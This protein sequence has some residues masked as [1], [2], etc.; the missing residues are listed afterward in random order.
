MRESSTAPAARDAGHVLPTPKLL[1]AAMQQNHD[2]FNHY[3][4]GDPLPT[5]G[6]GAW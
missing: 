1:R 3:I 5:S 6:T 2:W 4:F